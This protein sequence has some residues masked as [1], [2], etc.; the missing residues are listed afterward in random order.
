MTLLA[1]LKRRNVIRMAGLYL[2]GA[3]LIVQVASTR[4]AAASSNRN[5][6]IPETTSHQADSFQVASQA[7]SS[8]SCGR[9]AAATP[10]VSARPAT[11]AVPAWTTKASQA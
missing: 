11:E 5:P 10:G 6:A 4:A 1:E 3:W 8:S 9:V 7:S 2:V